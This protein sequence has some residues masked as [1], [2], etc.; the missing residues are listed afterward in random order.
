MIAEN[1]KY[2]RKQ[3]GITQRELAELTGIARAN[4][5][6]YEGGRCEPPIG[7]FLILAQ[8]YELLPHELY[9][10]DVQNRDLLYFIHVNQMINNG[11]G[12]R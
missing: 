12:K 3:K 7:S 10:M 9:F 6:A 2:L 8:F 11:M 4:I 5:N 1:L